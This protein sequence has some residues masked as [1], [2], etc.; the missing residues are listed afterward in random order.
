VGPPW[1]R[2]SSPVS[3]IGLYFLVHT[4]KGLGR[5]ESSIASI[6]KGL[7]HSLAAGGRSGLHYKS[8]WRKVISPRRQHLSWPSYVSRERNSGAP[9]HPCALCS[10][11]TQTKPT[12][13]QSVPSIKTSTPTVP[14]AAFV[15]V[16]CAT[17]LITGT[18]PRR[19]RVSLPVE[20]LILRLWR[21]TRNASFA[22]TPRL[23]VCIWDSMWRPSS[24]IT[25]RLAF[26]F[27]Y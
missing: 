17:L 8:P 27:Q 7:F 23:H 6:G 11:H 19:S 2:L 16:A 4:I 15:P 20:A 18:R 21:T 24:V 14:F 5:I 25:W 13:A 3:H 26:C 1:Q 12:L 10:P 22:K 9:E